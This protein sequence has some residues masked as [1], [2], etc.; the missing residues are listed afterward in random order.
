MYVTHKKKV[1]E[2]RGE[3]NNRQSYSNKDNKKNKKKSNKKKQY[4][5]KRCHSYREN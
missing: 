5:I 4:L 2:Q 1:K 3:S